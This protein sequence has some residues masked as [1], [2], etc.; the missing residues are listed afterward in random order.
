M[1]KVKVVIFGGSGFIG[2][3]LTRTLLENDCEVRIADIAPSEA[4]G[5]LRVDC[6]VRNLEQVL[7]AAEGM[8]VIYNLA[9]EHEDDVDPIELYYQTNVEGAR[10]VCRAAEQL[11]IRRI[12]FTSSVA[13][14]GLPD[15]EADET[16]E[17]DPF[18]DYGKSKLQAEGV[19]RGWF[20]GGENRGLVIVR[21]TVVFGPNNRRN[22]FLFLN[23]IVKGRFLMVGNGKNHKSIAYVENVAAFLNYV[24]KFETGE[25]TFNYIDKPDFD[26]NTLVS[27]IKS[28]MGQKSSLGP[29]LPYA[30]GYAMGHCC[31]VVAF[32]SRKKLPISAVR[33]KKFCGNTRFS[34]KRALESGFKPPVPIREGLERTLKYEFLDTEDTPV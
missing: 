30:L 6:D 7:K 32:V 13:I 1:S 27:Q 3:R 2:T 18:N 20:E 22:F 23:Q 11:G 17:P 24:R 8:D 4:H 12:I 25:Q 28:I 26:M 33:I 31:D 21:P 10:I 16:S 15:F 14:Y 5:D 34:A 29:R 19:Y 9:A